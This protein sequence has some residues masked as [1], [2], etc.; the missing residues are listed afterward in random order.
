MPFFLHDWLKQLF[1]STIFDAICDIL[2]QSKEILPFFLRPIRNFENFFSPADRFTEFK[3]FSAILCK[4]LQNFF[5]NR[6]TK[7]I[8]FFFLWPFVKIYHIYISFSTT[9]LLL[10]VSEI[11]WR[12]SLSF[13][14]V[15]CRNSWFS[16]HSWLM[17]FFIFCTI[18]WLN[19]RFL[20][21]WT[22]IEIFFCLGSLDEMCK[23]LC[24]LLMKFVMFFSAIKWRKSLCFHDL[25]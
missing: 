20:R 14:T 23:F 2:I 15:V 4:I 8:F 18:I 25:S 16:F 12:N 17:K 5:C 1:L 22:K 13:S 11:F 10:F 3:C 24:I 6:L 9:D 19:F 21:Y 7:Y